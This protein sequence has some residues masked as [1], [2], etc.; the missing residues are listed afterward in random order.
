M[1]QEMMPMMQPSGG[2]NPI[3]YTLADVSGNAVYIAY[4]SQR[5]DIIAWSYTASQAA[6]FDDDN[7]KVKY[8]ASHEYV[9]TYRKNCSV[10]NKNGTSQ[11]TAG[12]T[13]TYSYAYNTNP[14]YITVE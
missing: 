2:G 13:E 7:I 3:T 11:K 6:V 4:T 1:F 9:I 8:N 10:T 12:T 14:Y 5:P